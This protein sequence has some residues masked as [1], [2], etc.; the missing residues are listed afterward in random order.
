MFVAVIR[1]LMPALDNR[2]TLFRPVLHDPGRDKERRRQT[3]FVEQI[4]NPRQRPVRAITAEAEIL[5]LAP[6]RAV[7][8]GIA[9]G[10]VEVE[11]QGQAGFVLVRPGGLGGGG[12]R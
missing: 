7:E 9:G 4:E 3:E 1:H 8:H 12:H 6:D 10:A 5:G 11:G 2:L